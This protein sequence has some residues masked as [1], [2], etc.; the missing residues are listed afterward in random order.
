MIVNRLTKKKHYISCIINENGT[1]RKATAQLLFLNISKFN[2]FLSSLFSDRRTWL[3]SQ[4]WQNLGRIFGISINLF[5][6][7]YSRTKQIK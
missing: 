6:F 5:I 2:G 7:F 3:I 4:V 1:V